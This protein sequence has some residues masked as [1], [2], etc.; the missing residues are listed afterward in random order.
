MKHLANPNAKGAKKHQGRPRNYDGKIDHRNPDINHFKLI[1]KDEAKEIRVARVYSVALKMEILLVHVFYF[2]KGGKLVHKLYFSADLELAPT[3][4]L[5][6][7]S[8]RFQ[9]EFIYRDGKQHTGLNHCQARSEDKLHLHSNMALTAINLAK[10]QYCFG[11]DKNQRGAFSLDNIKRLA[12]NEV[13]LE[14][15]LTEFG[16]NPNLKKNTKNVLKL[17]NYSTRAA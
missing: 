2:H 9:I 14:L 6:M 16:I 11:L 10:V 5:D 7:Y 12:H 4:L 3:K 1:Q 8:A 17:L 15:F 13:M